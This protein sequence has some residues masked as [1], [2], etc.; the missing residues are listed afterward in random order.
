VLFT[1]IGDLFRGH[2]LSGW[3]KAVWILILIFI[4]FLKEKGAISDEEF[5]RLKARLVG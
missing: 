4:P 5:R 3:V 2:E 1:I